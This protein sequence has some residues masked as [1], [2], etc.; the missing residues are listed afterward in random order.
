MKISVGTTTSGNT[1]NIAN[2]GKVQY[3]T[4]QFVRVG[5]VGSSN[6][7]LLHGSTPGSAGSSANWSLRVGHVR[8]GE[9]SSGDELRVSNG[10]YMR[11]ETAS[12][13]LSVRRL[14]DSS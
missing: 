13:A 3:M 10:A 4:N 9:G 14:C 6:D 7:N 2:G 11:R 5:N 1:L 12:N 8:I